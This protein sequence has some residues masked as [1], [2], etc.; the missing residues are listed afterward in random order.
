MPKVWCAECHA[1]IFTFEIKKKFQ[2]SLSIVDR[3]ASDIKNTLSLD[4]GGCRDR[5]DA[6]KSLR[7]GC[8]Y[9]IRWLVHP[10]L[11]GAVERRYCF[12]T[13]NEL[14]RIAM[15]T[16]RTTPERAGKRLLPALAL[17]N[18]S[19][20]MLFAP[21]M[22]HAHGY[23]ETPP[24]RPL[25]CFLEGAENPKSAGCK[26]AKAISGSGPFYDRT[27]NAILGV[28]NDHEKRIPDGLLC[29]GGK[30]SWKGMDAVAD[31]SA[32][33]IK[34]DA[35]GNYTL[36]YHQTAQHISTYFRTYITK[37]GYD[38]TRP[39]RW[40]DLQLIGDTGPLPRQP[41]TDIHV[42]IPSG[43][44]GKRVLYTVWQ[45][46]PSDNAEGFYSCN[47]VDIVPSN[48]NWLPSGKIENGYTAKAGQQVVLRVFDKVRNG[49]IETHTITVAANSTK[50][51]DWIYA[52]AV[53]VNKKSS[54][55]KIGK[56]DANKQIVPIRS[57]T[58]NEL[59]GNGKEYSYAIELKNG[60]GDQP[61]V[62]PPV[63]KIQGPTSARG[64]ERVTLTSE[65]SSDPG[66]KP[67]QYSWTFPTE[68][69]A[70]RSGS[71]VTF[72]APTLKQDRNYEF[73]LH[74]DNG[75]SSATATHNLMVKGSA[76][77]S[78]PDNPSNPSNPGNDGSNN[79]GSGG[80]TGNNPGTGNYPAYQAG[81]AYKGGEIV[82][83]NGKLYQCKP[84]PYSG[85]CGQAREAY[86]P[87]KGWAWSDA[88]IAK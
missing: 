47:D 34:P 1:S 44:S 74:V 4:E 88:W 84:Y 33:P 48:V 14:I 23:M 73:K 24:D 57:A 66:G 76:G 53:D 64:G 83:H 26:A 75:K 16:D 55:V 59:F 82:S 19:A 6:A 67:L 9:V 11:V 63:A 37:N 87:G 85:W 15:R 25:A 51:E 69:R 5:C 52:L 58:E 29:A 18:L 7:S 50:P 46:D 79:P 21:S 39:I 60:G 49:D 3:V 61:S 45:R 10:A 72:T 30:E 22:S 56:L 43:M 35:Q 27:S 71:S 12:K 28:V 38:F 78:Q 80:D 77:G 32:T 13:S 41:Y 70:A 86:E 68:V 62:Q 42:K 2:K 65:G 36:R 17:I 81:F 54:I 40:S 8:S 31:W 20:A